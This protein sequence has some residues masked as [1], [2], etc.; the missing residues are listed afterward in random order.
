MIWASKPSFVTQK[1]FDKNLVGIHKN[2]TTLTFIKSAYL[3]MCIC[4]L[5]EV[6][7]YGFQYDYIKN[8]YSNK[9]RLL[10]TYTG[11]N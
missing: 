9:S 2:Q 4:E 10:F 6:P 8:K 11:E 7:M 1:I 5:S 3:G